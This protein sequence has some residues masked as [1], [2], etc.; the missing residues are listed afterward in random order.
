MRKLE[1]PFTSKSILFV[2]TQVRKSS[3]YSFF[4]INAALNTITLELTN[5]SSGL[6]FLTCFASLLEINNKR[7]FCMFDFLAIKSCILNT[8]ALRYIYDSL[9]YKILKTNETVK[10]PIIKDTNFLGGKMLKTDKIL[11]FFFFA[12]NV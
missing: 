4:L 6:F 5:P 1:S 8:Y 10:N 7:D 2:L 12:N 3:S 11:D 9:P